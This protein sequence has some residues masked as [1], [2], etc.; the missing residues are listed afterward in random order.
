MLHSI[1]LPLALLPGR[2]HAGA[3]QRGQ[4]RGLGAG[5]QV[6]LDAAVVGHDGE[7]AHVG[8]RGVTGA[9]AQLGVLLL[10]EEREGLRQRAG[11]EP[12]G[13]LSPCGRRNSASEGATPDLMWRA[14]SK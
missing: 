2:A 14:S 9:L 8:G 11:P 1:I 12:L 7:A 10:L 13:Q 4:R 5:R 3:V 6:P